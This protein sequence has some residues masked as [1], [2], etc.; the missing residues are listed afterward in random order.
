MIP[1]NTSDLDAAISE[2][3]RQ[4]AEVEEL[5]G[6]LPVAALTWR[7][8]ESKWSPIGHVAHLCI[9]NER[10]LA[11]LRE[12]I[13]EARAQ[14]GPMSD[15]PYR[16][17]R[18]GSWFARS[19]EPP[20][21]RRLKTL[22]SMVPDPTLDSGDVLRRF[23]VLQGEFRSAMENGRGLDLG[24]VRFGSPFLALIRLS[25]GTGFALILAHNRRHIWLIRE[26]M[27]CAGFPGG[28]GAATG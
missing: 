21:K 14:G 16:H 11:A 13:D 28:E 7:P 1:A 22:R 20:P 4:R 6:S 8:N 15:G 24:R 23:A 5:L 17:P 12:R 18:I 2:T 27:A 3:D 9:V 19:M 26:V 25:L 10:Y